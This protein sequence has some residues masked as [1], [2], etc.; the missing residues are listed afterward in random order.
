MTGDTRV[1]VTTASVDPKDAVG[2]SVV[3]HGAVMKSVAGEHPD[4]L[5]CHDVV[6]RAIGFTVLQ[7]GRFG[8]HVVAFFRTPIYLCALLFVQ[9]ATTPRHPRAGPQPS[10]TLSRCACV[11]ARAGL[12]DVSPRPGEPVGAWDVAAFVDRLGSILVR[13]QR[14]VEMH[15]GKPLTRV[16]WIGRMTT[17]TVGLQ[18]ATRSWGFRRLYSHPPTRADRNVGALLSDRN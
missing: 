1:V 18:R 14:M 10:T 8:S 15:T 3:H 17:A 5:V 13:D 12:H 11:C 7:S 4:R 2:L 16:R 6:L 9:A